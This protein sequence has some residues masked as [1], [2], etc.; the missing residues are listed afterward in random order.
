MELLAAPVAQKR[1]RDAKLGVGVDVR[2]VGIVHLRDQNLE[3]S[4]PISFR[5][6]VACRNSCSLSLTSRMNPCKCFTSDTR[7]SRAR[8]P[9]VRSIA[10]SASDVTSS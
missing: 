10:A 9:A 1:L 4:L 3:A 2:V 5:R 6:A 7:I 8:G